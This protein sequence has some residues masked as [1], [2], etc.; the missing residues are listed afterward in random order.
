MVILGFKS[1]ADKTKIRFSGESTAIVGPNG[2]GK[3]NVLDALKW[4]LGD[5]SL[6]SLRGEKMEDIV[7]SGS[8]N[9]S[10]ANY[11]E[12]SITLN[13]KDRIL[14]T[15]LD[16]VHICRRYYRDGQSQIFLNHHRTTLRDLENILMDTGLGKSCYSFMEQGK[17]DMILSS[18]PDDRKYIFEEAAGV[19]RFKQQQEEAIQK[20]ES[21]QT[22]ILRVK[23][24]L[25]KTEQELAIK[26]SQA[27]KVENY[28]KLKAHID[29]QD[30]KIKYF[31]IKEIEKKMD[32]LKKRQIQKKSELEKNRQKQILH[33]EKAENWAK[34]KESCLKELYQK[35]SQVRLDE[36]KIGQSGEAIDE[37]NMRIQMLGS[38]QKKIK[39]QLN[40]G[41]RR[42]KKLR[43]KESEVKQMR[44][45]LEDQIQGKIR[46]QQ[47]LKQEAAT[48]E[49]KIKK[50]QKEIHTLNTNQRDKNEKVKKLRT[51][52]GRV[53]KE[54]LSSLK[55]EKKRWLEN[56]KDKEIKKER[57]LKQVQDLFA[58]LG[59]YLESPNNK[60]KQRLN[61]FLKK[62]SYDSW[63]ALVSELF[64][65]DKNIK[66]FFFSEK[67]V[68]SLK[69][70]LDDKIILLEKE[71]EN[72]F[73]LLKSSEKELQEENILLSQ[74]RKELQKITEGVK[75]D[76]LQ[77][78]NSNKENQNLKE[79]FQHGG[80][81]IDY[82]RKL[83]QNAEKGISEFLQKE[84]KLQQEIA[85]YKKNVSARQD[86]I[87]AVQ[88]KL[89]NIESLRD[90]AFLQSRRFQLKGEQ[91]SGELNELE[92]KAGT[93]SGMQESLIKDTYN[94][95][96]MSLKEL[97]K[98]F[99]GKR[100]NQEKIKQDRSQTLKEIQ[101]L[102]TI[103]HLAVEEVEHLTKERNSLS[104]QLED[105]IKAKTH[106]LGLIEEIIED[107]QK[108]FLSTFALIKKNFQ[109]TFRALFGGGETTLSLT[110]P[111]RPLQGGVDIHVRMPGKN[112]KTIRLLSGGERALTAIAL[113]F[114]VYM[115]RSSPVCVL[116][117]IDASLDDQN[118][119]RLLEL[120]AKF[121]SKTQFILITH[122][123]ITVSQ[124]GFIFGITMEEPGVSKVLEVDLKSSA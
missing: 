50:L 21:T 44:L 49:K 119:R 111:E 66:H 92:I 76:K 13:N 20:L 75:I 91:I 99:Q 58:A 106:T 121:K 95:Y 85:S 77:K 104:E 5:R 39:A 116:D 41:E 84:K 14:G 87:K 46:S 122:N 60:N 36:E 55:V 90:E 79:Q 88:N 1:F 54:L 72:I 70:G 89:E 117:E 59:I 101:E 107:S 56:T 100:I 115:V 86:H 97:D 4:V 25:N 78:E 108:R 52:H 12:V 48:K 23:D 19:S 62:N 17:I 109:E 22:N 102:G 69:E 34:E 26:S 37:A 74:A 28:K 42:M 32:L 96:E 114:A 9:K 24:I 118:V 35:Q 94:Q 51:E 38:D 83:Y 45:Q 65:L 40:E 11:A 18:K 8:E 29:Q 80:E 33:T 47:V 73:R 67:G 112:K 2:C 120:L 27:K 30:I 53:T 6:R 105:I 16:Q 93:L 57:F 63:H 43:A 31:S 7:F 61:N 81:Q 113:M 15:S 110:N 103:N 124:A 71:I 82:F 68:F 10:P 64:D 98:K 3:S 123:K